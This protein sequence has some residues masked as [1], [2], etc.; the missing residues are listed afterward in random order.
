MSNASASKFCKASK[1]V[2]CGSTEKRLHSA[3]GGPAPAPE[4]S[5]VG[6]QCRLAADTC[7]RGTVVKIKKN[8]IFN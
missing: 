5:R 8:T 2:I 1:V 3:D 4:D 7:N 6:R